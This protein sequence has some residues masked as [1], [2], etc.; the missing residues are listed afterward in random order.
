MSMNTLNI[1]TLPWNKKLVTKLTVKAKGFIGA[2]GLADLTMFG[3][4][5]IHHCWRLEEI[6]ECPEPLS[7]LYKY[8]GVQ[9]VST[10]VK[11]C[12]WTRGPSPSLAYSN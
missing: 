1:V 6:N 12:P 9:A 10:T 4:F 2:D 5:A 3:S 11:F 7:S 8:V